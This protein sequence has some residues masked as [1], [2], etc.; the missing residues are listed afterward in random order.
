M[1]VFFLFI[2]LHQALAATHD[3]TF[4][5][6]MFYSSSSLQDV[7]TSISESPDANP[8]E[9]PIKSKLVP[10]DAKIHYLIPKGIKGKEI[11]ETFKV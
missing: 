2:L 11:Q 4:I 9:N 10:E 5:S 6:R 1:K 8:Q 3:R 7:Y